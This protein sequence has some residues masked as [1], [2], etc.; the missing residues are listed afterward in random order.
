MTLV[1]YIDL[2]DWDQRK[3][4]ICIPILTYLYPS[5]ANPVETRA[6]AVLRNQKRE[7]MLA[8]RGHWK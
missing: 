8:K 2:F 1:K 3:T 7:S 6:S 5:A 4:A